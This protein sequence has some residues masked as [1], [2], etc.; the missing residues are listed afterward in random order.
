VDTAFDIAQALFDINAAHMAQEDDGFESED[1]R[2]IEEPPSPQTST[3]PPASTSAG[4]PS[5]PQPTSS[6]RANGTPAGHLTKHTRKQRHSKE[7][8]ARRRSAKQQLLPPEMRQLKSIALKKKKNLEAIA[9]PADAEELHAA[10]TGWI[11]ARIPNDERTFT[12]EEVKKAP[13]NLRHI[14]W[15]GRYVSHNRI[16]CV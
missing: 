6:P 2:D 13:Y 16:E 10:S 7:S 14:Q 5:A 11:G 4:T 8:R 15:D 9:T 12:L 1:E 3:S